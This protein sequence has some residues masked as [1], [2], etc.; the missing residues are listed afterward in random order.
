LLTATE[1]AELLGVQRTHI[2]YLVDRGELLAYKLPT[3]GQ[4][5]AGRLYIPRGEVLALRSRWKSRGSRGAASGGQ[6]VTDE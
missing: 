5:R 1:A 2:H 3:K 6:D 4:V